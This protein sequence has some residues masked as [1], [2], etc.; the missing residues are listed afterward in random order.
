MPVKL[1]NNT[2]KYGKCNHGEK[3]NFKSFHFESLKKH[4]ELKEK[5]PMFLVFSWSLQSGKL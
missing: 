4:I 1:C 3:C 2:V 5:K